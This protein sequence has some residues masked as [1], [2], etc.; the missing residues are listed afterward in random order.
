KMTVEQ[1]SKVPFTDESKFEMFG[2]KRR[3][4]VRRMRGE[5]CINQYITSMVKHGGGSVIVWGCF[6]NN[7]VGDLIHI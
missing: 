7:K 3:V 6:G 5:R 1:W 4:Y 2:G